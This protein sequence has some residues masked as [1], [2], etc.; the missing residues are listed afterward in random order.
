MASAVLSK[1]SRGP[2]SQLGVLGV[3]QLRGGGLP[4]SID[5][6]AYLSQFQGEGAYRIQFRGGSRSRNRIRSVAQAA[7]V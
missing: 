6:E 3:C 1:G 2:T 5:E 7:S 4:E